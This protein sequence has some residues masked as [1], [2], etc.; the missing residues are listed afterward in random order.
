[1][2]E[3]H[4]VTQPIVVDANVFLRY[5]VRAETAQDVENAAAAASLFAQTEQGLIEITTNVAVI[6]E[7]VFIL[8]SRR[9][10]GLSREESV[11]KLKPLLQL[12]ACFLQEKE[13]AIMALDRWQTSPKISYVDAV[14]IEQAIAANS[15]LATF[16]NEIQKTPTLQI[17]GNK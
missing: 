8:S 6:A 15:S 16:D 13:L 9:H 4:A 12:P 17:W 2:D 5:I 11:I 1:V 7:V 14:V 10:Y 3:I